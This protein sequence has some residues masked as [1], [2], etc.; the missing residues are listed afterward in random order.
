MAIVNVKKPVGSSTQTDAVVVALVL[1]IAKAKIFRPKRK[2][3]LW[4]TT[5]ADQDLNC[6][7]LLSALIGFM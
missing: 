7:S 2:I 6:T 1:V 5:D 4:S 3:F